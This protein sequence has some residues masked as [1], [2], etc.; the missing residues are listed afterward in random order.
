MTPK[1]SGIIYCI[2]VELT[3]AFSMV[4]IGP[5]SFYIRLKVDKNR[6]NRMIK[7]L[8]PAYIDKVVSKFYYDNV[9]MVNTLI[10]EI[11][12]Y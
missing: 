4:D 2:K 11:S 6:E 1:E 5:I 12:L 3:T 8:Q 7:L 9:N 10:K